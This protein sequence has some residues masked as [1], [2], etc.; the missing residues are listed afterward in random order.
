VPPPAANGMTTVT[1]RDG[2]VLLQATV[3]LARRPAAPMASA[4]LRVND[5]RVMISPP[6]PCDGF[7]PVILGCAGS[8]TTVA[9]LIGNAA[10]LWQRSATRNR[11][12]RRA[13]ATP[14]RLTFSRWRMDASPSESKTA[15]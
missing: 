8:L 14:Y 11:A 12:I 7:A 6:V 3:G 2:Q 5:V 9:D 4:V 1:G 10:P 13:P 15:A